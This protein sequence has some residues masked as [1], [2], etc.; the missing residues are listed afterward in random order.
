MFH[1]ELPPLEACEGHLGSSAQSTSASS[2]GFLEQLVSHIP[3][4]VVARAYD[5]PLPQTIHSYGVVMFADISGKNV[6]LYSFSP[7]AYHLFD[8]RLHY[9]LRE[10]LQ[11]C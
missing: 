10:V 1:T 5:A 3:D 6:S 7:I 2:E 8:C 9:A 11:W 4:L